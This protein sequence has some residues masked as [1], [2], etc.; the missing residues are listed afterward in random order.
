MDEKGLDKLLTGN[1]HAEYADFSRA[2]LVEEVLFEP[3]PLNAEKAKAGKQYFRLALELEKMADHSPYAWYYNVDTLSTDGKRELIQ[4]LSRALKQAKFPFLEKRYAFQLLKAYRYAGQHKEAVRLYQKQFERNSE[5]DM[6]DYWAMD[7]I[8][9]VYLETEQRP[10]GFYRFLQVFRD[11][12]TRRGSAYRSFDIDNESDWQGTYALCEGQEEK[13]LMH[14]LRGSQEDAL[15]LE[16]AKSIFSLL[17]NHQWLKLL[18]TREINK[19]EAANLDYLLEDRT[20]VLLDNLTQNGHLLKNEE[21][22]AYVQELA[23]FTNTIYYNNRQDGFWTVTKAYLE[24]L[25]G[26]LTSANT[27][28]SNNR[29]LKGAD[30]RVARELRLVLLVLEKEKYTPEEERY[31]AQELA[32]VFK[33]PTTNWYTDRNNQEFVLGILA[34]RM[35]QQGR[36][37]LSRMLARERVYSVKQNPDL[38]TVEELLGFV[39]QPGHTDLELMAIK[40]YFQDKALWPFFLQAPAATADFKHLLLDMKGRLLMRDPE[41]LEAALAIFEA[42]PEK[43]DFPLRHN[44]FNMSI[45]DCVWSCKSRTS[46]SYTRN[47]FVRKLAEMKQLAETTQ[48]PTDYY[49]L[50]NA[51]YNMTY[52]GPAY[53]VMNYYRSGSS[54]DGFDDCGPALAFYKRA[55]ETASSR[56]FA[57]KACFMAAKAEQNLLFTYLSEEES[58]SNQYWWGK[59]H[60]SDGLYS[61]DGA[62]DIF[63]RRAKREGYRTY[64]EQLRTEYSD[65]DY[66]DQAIQECKYLE[67]YVRM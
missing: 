48:S 26:Q 35:E 44:P 47:S 29:Q 14:F 52:F 22:T 2:V 31:I 67:Y 16:D 27:T 30:R 50:G 15:G 39:R 59:Y 62:Y 60:I 9:G 28:L 10:Q 43:F 34:H 58:Q 5:R 8:A 7:H 57:A 19:I 4:K 25:S 54:Y 49:L 12:E 17:G 65:T 55:V 3:G 1:H 11:S 36:T 41:Q 66:Y 56:E 24:L 20:A 64:F 21:Y 61:D 23:T 13:A 33:D 46:T 51:Y 45:D 40:H 37:M 53:Y 63:Q 38:A 42:L 32:E 18:I 6:I